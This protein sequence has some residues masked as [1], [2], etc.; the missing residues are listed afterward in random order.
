L[1]GQIGAVEVA[2]RLWKETGELY[3]S[4]NIDAG[5]EESAKQIAALQMT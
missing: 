2:Y 3:R 1:K 4:E 5:V